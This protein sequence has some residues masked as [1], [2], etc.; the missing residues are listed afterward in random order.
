M[1][2]SSRGNAGATSNP[3]HFAGQT[4]TW[5]IQESELSC[6]ASV[7]TDNCTVEDRSITQ[8]GFQLGKDTQYT[9]HMTTS[10][11]PMR[12]QAHVLVEL[13]RQSNRQNSMG[14]G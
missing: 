7:G 9:T 2:T 5:Y 4:I 8:S 1:V 13:R 12:N 11:Q 6:T 14:F 10:V 3:Y